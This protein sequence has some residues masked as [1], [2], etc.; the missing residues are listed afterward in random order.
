VITKMPI[1]WPVR[2]SAM[3]DAVLDD[4]AGFYRR[5]GFVEL[6]KIENRLFLPMGTV[7]QLFRKGR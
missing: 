6:P 2:L 5:Y 4:M 3:A 7:E 1:V